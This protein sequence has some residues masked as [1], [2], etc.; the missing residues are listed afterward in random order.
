MTN[1]KLVTITKSQSAMNIIKIVNDG[2]INMYFGLILF[3]IAVTK[4]QY[5]HGNYKIPKMSATI[6]DL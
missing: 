3:Y 1:D 5:V 2:S 4:R 6:K